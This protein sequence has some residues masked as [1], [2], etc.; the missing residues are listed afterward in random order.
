MKRGKR[1]KETTHGA[2]IVIGVLF[3]FCLFAALLLAFSPLLLR[4]SLFRSAVASFL[5]PFGELAYK[6]AYI[7][8]M[9]SLLGSAIAITGAIWTQRVLRKFDDEKKRKEEEEKVRAEADLIL[10]ELRTPLNNIKTILQSVLPI[11]NSNKL[12]AYGDAL[13]KFS[14]YVQASPI[15]CDEEIRSSILRIRGKLSNDTTKSLLDIQQ[16]IQKIAILT[17]SIKKSHGSDDYQIAYHTACS[18]YQG[19]SEKVIASAVDFELKQA[20]KQALD[21][22]SAFANAQHTKEADN[23]HGG[24]I[25]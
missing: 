12:P 11:V 16:K 3:G 1:A 4:W 8:M 21:E 22:L 17:D 7:S 24:E 23:R 20:E 13:V 19:I 14:R 9:S 10:Y 2:K 6:N 5:R 18:L 15:I 25:K